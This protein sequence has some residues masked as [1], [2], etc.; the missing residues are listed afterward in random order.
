MYSLSD[1]T[2]WGISIT[3]TPDGLERYEEVAGH[4]YS[5]LRALGKAVADTGGELPDYYQTWA[6]KCGEG[7]AFTGP[8][9]LDP[10]GSDSIEYHELRAIL[11]GDA[12]PPANA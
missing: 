12:G 3:L 4:A 7:A 5:F 1:A 2:V 6:P 9:Q 10:D 11:C 8:L